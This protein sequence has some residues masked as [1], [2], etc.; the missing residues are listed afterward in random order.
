M[1]FSFQAALKE[2]ISFSPTAAGFHPV[3]LQKP[4]V[5][6]TGR[7]LED[8]VWIHKCWS[9][10]WEPGPSFHLLSLYCVFYKLE[11]CVNPALSKSIGAIFPT[12]SAHFVSLCHILTPKRRK[13]GPELHRCH[14]TWS[15]DLYNIKICSPPSPPMIFQA[16]SSEYLLEVKPGGRRPIM[17]TQP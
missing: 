16:K 15:L 14:S 2:F 4:S 3:C 5:R 11:I 6:S 12:A 7:F 10:S 13:T 17:K 8:S 1:D 9:S